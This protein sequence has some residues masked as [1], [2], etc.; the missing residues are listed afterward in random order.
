M[1]SAGKFLL[2]VSQWLAQLNWTSKMTD[3][4]GWQF[5]Y[6]LEVQLGWLLEHFH[7]VLI[8]WP[9]R[10]QGSWTSY[11]APAFPTTCVPERTR[12]KLRGLLWTSLKNYADHFCWFYW[13]QISHWGQPRFRGSSH[14]THLGI[15]LKNSQ[16]F[17]NCHNLLSLQL[18]R[19]DPKN[20][21]HQNNWIYAAE[22]TKW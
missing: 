5:G 9:E 22:K 13:L 11:V 6:W 16:T 10:F 2:R 12:W 19:W 17:L 7:M 20:M 8:A 1:G 3:S 14:R 21:F 18:Y 15:G 4:C